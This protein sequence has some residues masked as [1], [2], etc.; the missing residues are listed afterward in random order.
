VSVLCFVGNARGC[1]ED[2]DETPQPCMIVQVM[3]TGPSAKA[4]ERVDRGREQSKLR[5]LQESFHQCIP[6]EYH[7]YR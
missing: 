3:M 5:R 6:I 2:A 4:L 7:L 1:G